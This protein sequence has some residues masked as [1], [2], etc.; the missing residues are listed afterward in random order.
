MNITNSFFGNVTINQKEKT[1][2]MKNQIVVFSGFRDKKLEE[3]IKNKGGDVKS[4]VSSK[5]T[6]VIYSGKTSSKVEKA[7][8]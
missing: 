4:S 2:E 5:T 6:L 7:K 3:T 1:N 8:N